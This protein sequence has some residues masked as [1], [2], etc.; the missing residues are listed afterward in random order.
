MMRKDLLPG[1]NEPA[2]RGQ[3]GGA[4]SWLSGITG[5]IASDPQ[6]DFSPVPWG[7]PD[8]NLPAKP[9]RCYRPRDSW[10]SQYKYI[11]L[12]PG[13]T[14]SRLHPGLICTSQSEIA[15]IR[16]NGVVGS[17][18]VLSEPLGRYRLIQR[19]AHPSH[20]S[21]WCGIGC[22]YYC[23][24]PSRRHSAADSIRRSSGC[25]QLSWQISSAARRSVLSLR[26]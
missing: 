26:R 17:A 24:L 25:L 11:L 6:E 13:Q 19:S 16:C 23:L 15:C 10:Q 7:N 2:V 18:S 14:K 22:G 4:G 3:G 9:S 8:V 5:I 1:A 20:L 21:L 12:P